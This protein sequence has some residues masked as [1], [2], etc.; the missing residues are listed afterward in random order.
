MTAPLSSPEPGAHP[1][2]DELADL[3]EGLVES[4]EAARA[5]HRHLDGCTECRATA[6]AL[7][8]VR[9]LLGADEPE[10]MP[11]DVAARLDAALAEAA[12]TDHHS[13]A[14]TAQHP[15][16]SPRQA[17]ATGPR[18]DAPAAPVRAAPA[19]SAPPSR[20]A[21]PSGP[22]SSSGP[23][24]SGPGRP[25]PR[26]RR[27]AVLLG[28]AAALAAFGLG[29]ALLLDHSEH[30]GSSAASA[31]S[32][33]SVGV[34]GD[35]SA[36]TPHLAGPG[37]VYRED[38]LAAQVQ[39]LLDRSGTDPGL[40]ATGPARSGA[41]PAEGVRPE[42]SGPASPTVPASPASCQAPAPGTP[43]VTD[44]GSYQGSPVEVLVYPAPGR[45]GFVDVYLRS[46][47][48]GPVVLH[49]TVPGH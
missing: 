32:A 17:P 20:P 11:A 13:A 39:Q 26:R 18:T 7:T 28:A 15:Q 36:R 21:S 34:P 9:A 48:C 43:L 30:S 38:Q 5:L 37:T 35:Q 24:P 2:V 16:A 8:E 4:A 45:P 10:P 46:P 25:R 31:A 12:R 19:P 44:R 3:A 49:R 22:V 47:D 41:A 14:G 27:F 23:G 1:S 33:A 6:D 29:G 42:L 40:R